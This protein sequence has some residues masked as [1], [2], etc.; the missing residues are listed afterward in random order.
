MN[1]NGA[2]KKIAWKRVIG[3]DRTRFHRRSWACKR[4]W[5]WKRRAQRG[6]IAGAK[7]D[8]ASRWPS[9]PVA[10][11]LGAERAFWAKGFPGS[12]KSQPR[13]DLPPRSR[14]PKEGSIRIHSTLGLPPLKEAGAAAK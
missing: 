13:R 9:R 3:R 12:S 1:A 11:S 2:M 14:D 4:F 10:T 8:P 7:D 6:F 5:V